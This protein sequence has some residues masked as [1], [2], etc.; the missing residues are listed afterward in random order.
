MTVYDS[1]REI[2]IEEPGEMREKR[3]VEGRSRAGPR[4]ITAIRIYGRRI[5]IA[6]ESFNFYYSIYY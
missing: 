5:F 2:P 1:R 6:D 4:R 3:D